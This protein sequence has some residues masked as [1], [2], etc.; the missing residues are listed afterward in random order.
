M[1][2]KKPS[3]QEACDRL[4][5]ARKEHDKAKTV[6]DEANRELSSHLHELN[7]AQKMFDEAVKEVREKNKVWNSDWHSRLRGEA[8]EVK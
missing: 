8:V 2:A 3:M 6:A 4:D 5:A 7:A 1:E